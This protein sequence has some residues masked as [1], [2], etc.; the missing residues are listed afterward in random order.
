MP[1]ETGHTILADIKVQKWLTPRNA[2][3]DRSPYGS[4][5]AETGLGRSTTQQTQELTVHSTTS[6]A[7]SSRCPKLIASSI[8]PEKE[9]AFGQHEGRN[10][11]NS[12]LS[13]KI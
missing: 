4:S 9:A 11:L 3:G 10:M 8:P 13:L 7:L 6:N 12:S 5:R 1:R 2:P